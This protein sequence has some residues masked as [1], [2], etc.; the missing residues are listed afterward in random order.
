ML[1]VI[2]SCSV[3][4]AKSYY[5][6]GLKQERL[7]QG[8]YYV[9]EQ[10]LQ[11]QWKG[12]GAERLGFHGSIVPKA[13]DALCENRQPSTGQPLTPHTRKERRV[14]CLVFIKKP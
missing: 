2:K 12:L 13:F 14:G 11:G 1:R 6:L 7:G 3:K 4:Q 10:E 9:P 5:T 8:E